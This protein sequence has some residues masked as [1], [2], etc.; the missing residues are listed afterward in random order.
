MDRAPRPVGATAQWP[1]DHTPARYSVHGRETRRTW[2][3][4]TRCTCGKSGK[5]S[6]KWVQLGGRPTTWDDRPG[7]GKGGRADAQVVPTPSESGEADETRC[8]WGL[9]SPPGFHWLEWALRVPGWTSE[10]S[11]SAIFAPLRPIPRGALCRYSAGRPSSYYVVRQPGGNG[12]AVEG[13]AHTP[14]KTGLGQAPRVI[15]LAQQR[16][17]PHPT[18]N[19]RKLSLLRWKVNTGHYGGDLPLRLG[20]G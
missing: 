13:R 16:R 11:W 5:R 3:P 17:P 7:P 14:T 4:R 8:E 20:G 15:T 19:A 2:G 6:G 12:G 10:G 1:A 9:R 18:A